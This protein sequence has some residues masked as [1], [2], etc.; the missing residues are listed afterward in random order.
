MSDSERKVSEILRDIK[1]QRTEDLVSFKSLTD[2]LHEKGM[3]LLMA[4]FSIPMCIPIPYPPGFSTLVAISITV[5]TLQLLKQRESVWIPGWLASKSM[6]RATLVK[7]LDRAIPKL[8][9]MEKRFME[10]W[11]YF[12]NARSEI[13]VSYITLFLC[14][15][16]AI[17]LPGIHFFPGWSIMLMALGLLNRD[18]K[19]VAIG[20]GLS[21]FSVAFAVGEVL[22]GKTLIL[23]IMHP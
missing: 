20:M 14:I 22:L 18:G 9:W 13:S 23:A 11:Y 7:M 6:P 17:P 21:L 15:I 16:I 5:F 10:R 1:S 8:E 2:D 4:F 19:V 3:P 12:C